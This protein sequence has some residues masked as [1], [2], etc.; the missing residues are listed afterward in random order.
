MPKARYTMDSEGRIVPTPIILPPPPPLQIVQRTE[1]LP[2]RVERDVVGSE[3]IKEELV[4]LPPKTQEEP[5]YIPELGYTDKALDED[6]GT[7]EKLDGSLDEMERVDF[8]DMLELGDEDSIF[9]TGEPKPK[10]KRYFRRTRKPYP[11]SPPTLGGMR[12]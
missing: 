10:K 9:G 4:E 12:Y 11:P 6:F 5:N 1:R 8:A 3:D 7:G 2:Q